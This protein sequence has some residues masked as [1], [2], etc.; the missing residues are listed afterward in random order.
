MESFNFKDEKDRINHFDFLPTALI[1]YSKL[2]VHLGVDLWVKQDDLFQFCGGG[3]KAR[4]LQYILCEA[5]KNGYNALVTTGGAQSNHVRAS[6]LM[7]KQL[8]WKSKVVIHDEQ[9]KNTPYTG[10]LKLTQ[11][12]GAKIRF[13]KKDDV[14]R[15]M[16]EAMEDLKNDG[17]NPYYIW[18]GGHCVEGSYA[19]YK[20]VEEVCNQ[21]K[22]EDY[23][24][25]IVVASGTGTT[26]A[27]IVAGCRK[28]F[29]ETRVMGI[30]VAR[31]KERGSNVILESLRELNSYLGSNEKN[32][33][34]IHFDDSFVGEGYEAIYPELLETIKWAAETEGLILDPTYTGKAFHG[35]L[36]YVKEGIIPKGA[37]VLFWHTGGLLNLMAS[38]DI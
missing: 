17:Y 20:A 19:Y 4:K 11:L 21:L 38:K 14:T 22:S 5:Q 3:N 7:A 32:N 28:F 16:D 35:L 1:N 9:P 18:G 2:S 8:G 25:Y 23:P 31:D 24:E 29:P 12:A 27:G 33:S 26:Q 34:A 37:K 15:A 30:S 10:N 13:V 36:E 6:A